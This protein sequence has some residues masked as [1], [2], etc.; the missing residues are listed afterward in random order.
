MTDRRTGR[1]GGPTSVPMDS[2]GP[3]GIGIPDGAVVLALESTEYAAPAI[4]WAAGECRR[5]AAPLHLLVGTSDRPDCSACDVD[6]TV[7]AAR[8]AHPALVV[9]T[10]VVTGDDLWRQV[11][12]CSASAVIVVTAVPAA[13][14]TGRGRASSLL[15]RASCPVVI[16]PAEVPDP[17]TG[18]AITNAPV[19]ALVDPGGRAVLTQ[20]LAMASRR[21]SDLVVVTSETAAA[22]DRIDDLVRGFP[23]VHTHLVVP[24]TDPVGDIVRRADRAAVLVVSSARAIDESAGPSL[25]DRWRLT[26]PCPLIIV[27]HVSLPTAPVSAGRSA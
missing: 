21:W 20:A 11:R 13:T 3:V 12:A 2:G 9:T 18:P 19:L 4:I 7:S 10:A 5:R 14:A 24:D 22:E 1:T 25:L 6:R 17:V 16:T 8:A 26:T 23:D 15:E 27:P